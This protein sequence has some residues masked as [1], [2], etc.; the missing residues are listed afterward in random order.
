VPLSRS[1]VSFFFPAGVMVAVSALVL[2]SEGASMLLALHAFAPLIYGA[3]AFLAWRFHST[4]I[5]FGVA[6][7]AVA[8]AGLRAATGDPVA[9]AVVRDVA[10]ILLPADLIALTFLKEKGFFSRNTLIAGAVLAGQVALTLLLC[11]PEMQAA[12]LLEIRFLPAE[13]IRWSGAPQAALLL[14]M[15]SIL[16]LGARF[17]LLRSPVESGTF[18]A[19]LAVFSGFSSAQP[20]VWLMIAGAVL[21]VAVVENSYVMAFHDQLTGLPARRAFY[22]MASMLPEHYALAMA[23]VDHFKKFNDTFGHEIGDQVLRMVAARMGRVTGGGKAFRWGGEEFV[24]LFPGKSAADA[25]EHLEL[26]RQLVETSSFILRGRDRGKHTAEE[27]GQ[28]A[29]RVQ[30]VWVTVSIGVAEGRSHEDLHA[31][32]VSADAAVYA[33]KSAGRNRVEAAVAA[34]ARL[35]QAAAVP[36]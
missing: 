33:A 29:G 17:V 19:L 6:A 1:I 31:V 10:A 28:A 24:L 22:R 20:G 5:L 21:A 18:W 3:A 25:H 16:F 13:A 11:R 35:P 30:E 12:E 2:R 36:R 7:L 8:D 9:A 4:R 27:R 34:T 23:D 32:M 15:V 26:L 14:S